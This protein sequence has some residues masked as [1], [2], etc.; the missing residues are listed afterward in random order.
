MTDIAEYLKPGSHLLKEDDETPRDWHRLIELAA[1]LKKQKKSGTEVHYLRGRNIVLVFA[2]TST[3]TRCAFEVA[4]ADQGA[5]T[6][7]LDPQGSQMGHKESIS[8]TAHVLGRFFDAI[9]FRGDDQSQVN[10]L[11]ADSGVPVWNG[12]TAQWHPTQMLAD[13]LTMVEHAGGKSFSEITYS[14]VGDARYNMGRSLL[15]NGALLGCDVRIVAPRELWP[16]PEVIERGNE[17]AVATGATIT[18]TDDINMVAGSDFVHTDIWVSMGEPKDVWAERI[19][20]LRPYRV[21]EALM[22]LAGPNAKFMHCLPAFHDLNTTVGR[23]VFEEFG[24]EGIE[25]TD[26]VFSGPRSVVF[27]Q[28][29]NRLHTIKAVMVR[30]LGSM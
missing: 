2:K 12:L 15:I 16:D 19:E 10:I 25:V 6:T 13:S 21:D 5:S 27:D 23:Q 7:Y 9:E 18:V 26:E 3:R 1:I 11:A 17:I 4:A 28:A 30:S 20:L 29:E 14:Y 8:D 24:L 22:E